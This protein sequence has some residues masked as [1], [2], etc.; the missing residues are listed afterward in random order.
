MSPINSGA[1]GI[2]SSKRGSREL[3]A[4]RLPIVHV[5]VGVVVDDPHDARP[6]LAL[7]SPQHIV[8]SHDDCVLWVVDQRG[9]EASCGGCRGRRGHSNA[10]A[11]GSSNG[12][13]TV[14]MLFEQ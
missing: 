11:G 7:A 14:Q 9:V 4:A 6:P 8:V 13:G 12:G 5:L 3:A 2:R 10:A 1:R